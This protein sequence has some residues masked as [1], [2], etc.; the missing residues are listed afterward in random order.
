MDVNKAL[1]V[2]LGQSGLIFLGEYGE[3]FSKTKFEHLQNMVAGFTTY[4]SCNNGCL[5]CQY[6][7]DISI[8]G[9][10]SYRD[11]KAVFKPIVDRKRNIVKKLVGTVSK[12]KANPTHILYITAV[13]LDTNI[14]LKAFSLNSAEFV[15]QGI[16]RSINDNVAY[17]FQI[18]KHPQQ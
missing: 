7:P 9:F 1:Q 6:K 15:H 12:L 2:E 13:Y 8:P 17:I 14:P 16:D 3:I 18:V 10:L 11:N 5:F 4:K